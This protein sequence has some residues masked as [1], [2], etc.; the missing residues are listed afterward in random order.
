MCHGR[1][2]SV[3]EVVCHFCPLESDQTQTVLAEGDYVKIDFGVHVDGPSK[4]GWLDGV[5]R[6][7]WLTA[8]DIGPCA[9]G[10]LW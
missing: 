8:N 4:G 1:C 2:L 9:Q 7:V 10:S 6:S 5:Q 3:N